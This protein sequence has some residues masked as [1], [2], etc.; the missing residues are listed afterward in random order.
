MMVMADRPIEDRQVE[1][2]VGADRPMADP[3]DGMIDGRL[4]GWNDGWGSPPDVRQP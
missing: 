4:P 3:H 1:I 2:M